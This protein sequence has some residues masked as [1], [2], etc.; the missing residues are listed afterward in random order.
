MIIARV[1][2]ALIVAALTCGQAKAMSKATFNNADR[3]GAF[4]INPDGA[5]FEFGCATT[6]IGVIGP[7]PYMM[8]SVP[9]SALTPGNPLPHV[10]PGSSFGSGQIMISSM[11]GTGR[12]GIP[13]DMDTAGSFERDGVRY[14]AM[15]KNVTRQDFGEGLSLFGVAL[16][17][18]S[19]F[20]KQVE[21]GPR[22]AHFVFEAP[23]SDPNTV[24][25]AFLRILT[26][27]DA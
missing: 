6:K 5:R 17:R 16:K 20:T 25:K 3:F 27:C 23:E 19:I 4:W 18:V 10:L 12:G 11:A 2:F 26:E 22:V 15:A 14:F 9:E 8:V 21:H 24:F 1:F 13:F 7:G